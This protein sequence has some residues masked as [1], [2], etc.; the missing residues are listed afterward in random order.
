MEKWQSRLTKLVRY[1]DRL[2]EPLCDCFNARPPSEHPWPNGIPSSSALVAFYSLCDG[3]QMRNYEFRALGEL[4]PGKRG[5]EDWPGDVDWEGEKGLSPGRWLVLG[6]L[7]HGPPFIWDEG[8]DDIAWT[9]YDAPY[10]ELEFLG[11]TLDQF[12]ADL[13]CPPPD[14]EDADSP[15]SRL[16]LETLRE[17]DK[18]G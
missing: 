1:G 3:G 7:D 9:D 10:D 2:P 18:F 15:E 12:L 11:K 8:K 16:W 4:R 6:S 14:A 13:F 5:V 17:L